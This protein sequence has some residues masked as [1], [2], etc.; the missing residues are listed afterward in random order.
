MSINE[1]EGIIF[2][3]PTTMEERE[4]VAESCSLHLDLSI[5]MLI[6]EMNNQ[7]DEAY[8][9][10]PERLYLIDE[11]GRVVYRSSWGPMGFKPNEFE[12]AIRAHLYL[13][14]NK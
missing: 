1:S 3:Q 12:E 13:G 5:P 14:K 2:E 6:D 11:E 7:V 8:S 4:E 9:A 10:L